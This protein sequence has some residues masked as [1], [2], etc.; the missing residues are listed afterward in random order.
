MLT[1]CSAGLD[2]K[3]ENKLYKELYLPRQARYLVEEMRRQ[4]TQGSV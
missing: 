1:L 3:K 4:L 2:T